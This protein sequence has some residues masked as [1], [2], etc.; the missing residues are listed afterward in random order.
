MIDVK[1]YEQKE[2]KEFIIFGPFT[3]DKRKNTLSNLTRFRFNKMFFMLQ[4]YSSLIC[5]NSSPTSTS[6]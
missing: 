5:T 6:R 2:P 3:Y 4:S 1:A